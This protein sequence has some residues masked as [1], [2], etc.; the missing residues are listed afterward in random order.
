MTATD[1]GKLQPHGDRWQLT[2]T[3]RLPHRPD[4]VWRALTEAEHL[5]AWFPTTIEGDLETGGKLRFSFPFE[6]ARPWTGRC[7]PTTRPG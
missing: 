4:K 7:W 5:T 6:E 2:F 3:R 1:L